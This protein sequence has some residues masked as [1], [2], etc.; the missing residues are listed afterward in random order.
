MAEAILKNEGFV[1]KSCGSN[2]SGKVNENVKKLLK[3]KNMWSEEFYSKHLDEVIDEDF[4][5][6]ITVCDNAKNECPV[7]PKKAKKLHIPFEDPDGKEYLEFEKTFELIKEKLLK[8]VP[9]I[10]KSYK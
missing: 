3:S 9:D 1:V 8:I 4:D 2:P 5:L 10:K 6:V 7:F